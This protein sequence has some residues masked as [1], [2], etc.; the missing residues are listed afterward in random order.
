MGDED[1]EVQ[2]EGCGW[3]GYVT[4]LS[5]SQADY[6]SIKPS[7]EIKWDRC[8]ECDSTDIVDFEPDEDDDEDV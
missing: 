6:D 2:C 1:F 3:A 8:P 4:E 5:C 7:S